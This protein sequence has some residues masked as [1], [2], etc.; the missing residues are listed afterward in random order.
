MA[1]AARVSICYEVSTCCPQGLLVQGLIIRYSPNLRAR[2]TTSAQPSRII[3]LQS[4]DLRAVRLMGR[5]Q[6]PHKNRE[7]GT[8]LAHN[9]IIKDKEIC[10]C[11]CT[12]ADGP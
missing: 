3:R 7:S 8:H 4:A 2:H 5:I 10:G 12:T 9:L 6:E 11:R 1:P